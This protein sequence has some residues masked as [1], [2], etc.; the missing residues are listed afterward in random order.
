MKV[1]DKIRL[2][3][4]QDMKNKETIFNAMAMQNTYS[5]T[6][7]ELEQIELNYQ[8]A[9]RERINAA[10]KYRSLNMSVL[11]DDLSEVCQNTSNVTKNNDVSD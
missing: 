8:R 6:P 3:L 2:E 10:L 11:S 1:T 4:Y 7:E 9:K 5:K